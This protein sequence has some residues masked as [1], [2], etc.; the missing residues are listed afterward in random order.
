MLA[1]GQSYEHDYL[2]GTTSSKQDLRYT[3]KS[4]CLRTYFYFQYLVLFFVVP[5]NFKA[6]RANITD[7]MGN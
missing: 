3:Q 1:A 4:I 5:R 2:R 6:N 7:G